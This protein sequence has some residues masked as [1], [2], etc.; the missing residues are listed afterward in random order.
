M[1][2]I[3]K[4]KWLILVLLIVVA[5]GWFSRLV[6]EP[7]IEDGSFLLVDIQDSYAEAPPST[8]ITR[9]L[10]DRKL[11]V[12]LLATLNK[13][14]HDDRISGVVARI[15]TLDVGWAQADEIRA[16]LES[17]SGAGKQVVA[18][19][20]SDAMTGNREYFVASAAESVYIPPAGAPML[21]GLAANYL[22]F[23]GLWEELDIKIDVQQIG[24]YKTFGDT[25]SR[26]TMT[27][28]H[29]DMVNWI[30]D[31]INEE[32]VG[33]IAESRGLSTREMMSIIDS[34]PA[35]PGEFVESGLAD[36]VA[37]MDDVLVELGGGERVTLVTESVYSRIRESSLGIGGGPKIAVIH[38]AGSIVSGKGGGRSAIGGTVGA[39]TLSKAFRDASEDPEIKA[40]VF[41]IDSPGGSAMA[42]DQVWHASRVARQKKPVLA[43]LGDVAASGGYY[44]AA[45]ADKIVANAGTLTGS[46]GVVLLKPDISG[47]L[48][49]LGIGSETI[50]RGRYARIM[51]TT[52]SFD[53]AELSLI[54]DQMEGVYT[55]FLDRVAEGR[56][57][58]VE[59][60]DRIG[61]G[62]VWT[63]RQ[64]LD[65]G[66]VDSLGGLADTVRLAAGEA[67]IEELDSIEIV[68]LPEPRNVLDEIGTLYESKAESVIPRVLAKSFDTVSMYANLDAGIH[69]LMAGVLEIR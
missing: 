1:F 15:G 33:T 16:A 25:F 18:Y 4:W 28:A 55:R 31:D 37:F 19:V 45:G 46:I 42:S 10:E 64:A 54:R 66:L 27:P 67:G 14:R 12:N 5:A 53:R 60:V 43:S 65:H 59:E 58:T 2:S 63:G 30:L 69:A 35:T 62:R 34:C 49:K 20:D 6:A 57:M 21:T 7:K 61:E 9:L 52:K 23:G 17:V 29:R 47:L 44:M 50:A 38:A 24:E 39:D 3:F 41:R 8:S 56:G 40:I 11:F 32:F 22:F 13:A 51:D 68:H 36:K 48:A 26:K